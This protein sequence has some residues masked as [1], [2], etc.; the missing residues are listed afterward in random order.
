MERKD[1]VWIILISVIFLILASL[2]IPIFINATPAG[3]AEQ[4]APPLQQQQPQQPGSG[5]PAQWGQPQ[6]ADASKHLKTAVSF[7]NIGLIIPLFVIYAG[8]YRRMKSS[9]TLGLMA[10][11]FALGMYTVT[12]CPLIVSLAGGRTVDIGL[13][14]ILP[15]LCTTVALVILVRIS[16][17]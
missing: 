10:V 13:F 8:I 15:D 11:I 5:Q 9:F 16:L 4:N 14:Q 17:E 1:V 7:I 12:S 6:G 3:P 2:A